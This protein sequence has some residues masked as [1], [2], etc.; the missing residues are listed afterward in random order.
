MTTTTS[1]VTY[2]PAIA[3]RVRQNTLS[4][5][6]AAALMI[7]FGYFQLSRPVG[8]DLFH[9]AGLVFYYTLR[10][11]GLAMAGIALWS[12]MG[13]R[14]VLIVDAVVSIAIGVL[15]V[16]TGLAMWLDGGGMFQT[17]LNAVFGAMFISAG[18]RNWR[19]YSLWAIPSDRPVSFGVED[20][21]AR[22]LH[23]VHRTPL[24]PPGTSMAGELRRRRAQTGDATRMT[25]PP[26]PS[27][28]TPSLTP[29]PSSVIPE[30]PGPS[31]APIPE[32]PTHETADEQESAETPPPDG[33][34]L[35]AFADDDPP[36]EE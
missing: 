1:Q 29:A 10:L 17:I 16:L 11:G 35:A 33:G 28:T 15:F 3:S 9:Q 26:T 8:T 30:P 24:P 21:E 4:A 27:T 36:E 25:S 19:D 6:I 5:A 32:P 31:Q 7:Y 13:Q 34:F 2:T 14:S 12:M 23:E 22:Q 18:A 20:A